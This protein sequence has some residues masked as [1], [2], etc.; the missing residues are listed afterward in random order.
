MR[1]TKKATLGAALMT[2]LAATAIGIPTVV[3]ADDD[4]T[5]EV[6]FVGNNWDGTVDIV[7]ADGGLDKL[8]RLNVVPDLAERMLEI[9][10]NPV[11]L[12]Y[13]NAVRLLIGE[14]H[15]QLVD[16]MYTTPDG[17][18]LIVS[19][20]SLA[21][22]VGIDIGTGQVSWRFPV[23]G[24]RS[25]HMALSP[26]GQQVAVSA[27]TANKVHLL[28]VRTGR[29]VGSF[30]TGDSPHENVY[31]ADGRY[32]VNASI[33]MVYTPLDQPLLDS[34]KGE[35]YFQIVD[36]ATNTVVKRL[37]MGQKLKEAGYDDMSSA[38]RPMTFSPD[39]RFVYFQVSFF[40]GFVE[41]DLEQD[42]VTRLAE[43]P[44]A[45]HVKDTPR[46]GYL[47]DSAHHG[48]AMN[49]RGD[50]ICVAGTMSDYATIVDRATFTHRE[51]LASGTKPYWATRSSDGR[52]CY[53]SWSG[54]DKVT[55]ISY[56]TGKE[57]GNVSVGDHPQRMR[58]GK[59]RTSA[60]QT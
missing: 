51:L 18:M 49:T 28:D 36:R 37:D 44:V 60:L 50:K 32:I 34:T 5:R 57:V 33:G 21:D 20:P 4:P 42:K 35:R 39:E 47:L 9:T 38:V 55:A 45:D 48:I 11:R 1:R 19:R 14:G 31:T 10:L 53:V 7:S 40:H 46:E 56:D 17:T 15:D 52:Y 3:D 26:D 54:S 2:A 30:P 59:V 12:V 25:D 24:Q 16:D 27:S 22:V 58:L 23:E 8:G 13:F 6:L 43:L 29:Q 41:Y